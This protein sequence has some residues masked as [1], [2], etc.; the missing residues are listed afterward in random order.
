MSKV[1]KI[2]IRGALVIAPMLFVLLIHLPMGWSRSNGR[3]HLHPKIAYVL[4]P[5]EMLASHDVPQRTIEILDLITLTTWSVGLAWAA[6]VLFARKPKQRGHC[7]KCGYNLKGNPRGDCPECGSPPTMEPLE[8]RALPTALPIADAPQ[9]MAAVT[10]E[11]ERV[12]DPN[13]SR[14]ATAATSVARARSTQPAP[15]VRV[16]TFRQFVWIEDWER[17]SVGAQNGPIRVIGGSGLLTIQY[18]IDA[19]WDA[20][21]P[22]AANFVDTPEHCVGIVA[23]F[24]FMPSRGLQGVSAYQWEQIA[25]ENNWQGDGSYGPGLVAPYNVYT[26][27]VPFPTP[28]ALQDYP[29]QWHRFNMVPA[30]KDVQFKSELRVTQGARRGETLVSL[31]WQYWWNRPSGGVV[32]YIWGSVM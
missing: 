15:S 32:L 24:S 9:P 23:M 2:R 16:P 7:P 29:A 19:D 22:N 1:T 17:N 21:P 8:G 11:R 27:A 6:A 25:S 30:S 28:I 10:V 20:N 26:P 5:F 12:P 13:R 14:A 3:S 4:F 31:N 18:Q